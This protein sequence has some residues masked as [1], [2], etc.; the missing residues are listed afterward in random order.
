MEQKKSNGL[1]IPVIA[2]G[3]VCVVLAVLCA[4]LFFK[5]S[6]PALNPVTLSSAETQENQGDTE[7]DATATLMEVS[8]VYGNPDQA[9]YNEDYICEFS[10]DREITDAEMK[11]ILANYNGTLP[12]GT[13]VKQMMINEI[14]A[15]HGFF[16]GNVYVQ[17]YFVG[18]GWYPGV[19]TED[20]GSIQFSAVEKK[21]IEFIRNYGN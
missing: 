13:D 3:V 16:F 7:I 15:R 19:Q 20:A 14:F 6:V 10:S 9:A 5:K 12:K 21:N 8:E 2:L 11:D 4:V 1:L 17:V 18:K